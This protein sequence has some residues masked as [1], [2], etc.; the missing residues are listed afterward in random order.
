MILDDQIKQLQIEI[1][2]KEQNIKAIKPSGLEEKQMGIKM[3]SIVQKQQANEE[4]RINKMSSHNK[5]LKREINTLR[6]EI[7]G[8]ET[9]LKKY[10]RKIAK[11][12][13]EA[14]EQNN[15]YTQAKQNT[16]ETNNQII[17]LK[18]KHEHEKIRFEKEIENIQK[19]LKDKDETE[20]PGKKTAAEDLGIVGGSKNLKHFSN[21]IAILKR[22]LEKIQA[23][24]MQKRKLMEQYIRNV[25]VIQDAFDQ[26]K[27]RT[28]IASIDEIVT[29][30][31]KAEE[32]NYSL[33]N[34]VNRLNTETD[35]LDELNRER[36]KEIM[37]Y[38]GQMQNRVDNRDQHVSGLK[39]EI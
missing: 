21:P 22:R 6:K 11:A 16:E 32:Q 34:Y 28:G 18:A 3:N 7:M 39:E 4:L 8:A 17:S 19:K 10:N 29:T 33:Y 37:E 35:R 2:E 25:K 27:E 13:K 30:F 14:R 15:I 38:K 26:I 1:I 36:N 20:M 5:T 24:N 23:T 9:E 31:V 12:K